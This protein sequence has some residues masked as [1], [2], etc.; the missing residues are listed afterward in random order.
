MK[1]G[2]VFYVGNANEVEHHAAPLKELREIRVASVQETLQNAKAGDLAIF[3]S[4]HFHETREAIEKLKV[5]KVATLY[6]IDGILEW[7]NAWVNRVDEPACPWT[8]RP[9]LCHKVACIGPSQ[10]RILSG[11]GNADRLELVGIPRFD[12]WVKKRPTWQD[13]LRRWQDRTSN[14]VLV[15]TAKCPGFTA[16]QREVTLQS[17]RDL[18]DF[19]LNASGSSNSF[20]VTWRLTDDLAIDLGVENQL[21]SL[22]GHDLSAQLEAAD[23]VVATP[24]TAM[25]EAMLTGLPVVQLDYHQVPDLTDAAWKIQS[26]DQLKTC[27]QRLLDHSLEG[28]SD[29]ARRLQW[30]AR[31][32]EDTL[33]CSPQASL[34]MCN[35]VER[36]LVRAQRA[37][38]QGEALVYER[39][40]LP[41]GNTDEV[42]TRATQFDLKLLYPDYPEF[43]ES[44]VQ[45]LQQS[46]ADL[47][48]QQYQ[49]QARLDQ[50][51]AEL[52]EAHQIF[53]QIQQ[54]PIAGPI[55]RGRQRMLDW[56]RRRRGTDVDSESERVQS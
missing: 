8:M 42:W 43:Q 5:S 49:L 56:W 11:W 27:W 55:V 14:R 24:S 53:E 10:Y 50:L 29:M 52:G 45:A 46:T 21:G 48:R 20:D 35:L 9:S 32:L 38:Q 12:N 47:R 13:S 7:R 3:F 36:M 26:V 39:S 28:R 19:F 1:L 18:R 25:L 22:Q 4:E 6:A 31:I 51:Q 16:R 17:L 15:L 23:F 40:L 41:I 33:W 30:Q 54:H 2:N 37:V 44:D 34:R